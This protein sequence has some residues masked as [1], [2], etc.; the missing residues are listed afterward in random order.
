MKLKEMLTSFFLISTVCGCSTPDGSFSH[1]SDVFIPS[2]EISQEDS[3]STNVEYVKEYLTK[4]YKNPIYTQFEVADPSIIYC[5]EDNY[6]Y[7]LSTGGKI[8]KS[9]NMVYWYP[10]N[11]AFKQIPSWGSYNAGLWAPDIQYINGQYIM[12]YSLSAWNDPNPGIGIATANHP[13]GPWTDHGKLFTSK[14]IGV[15]NSIDPMVYQD[16]DGKI[17]MVWGSMR[18]NFMVELESDGLSLKGGLNYAV[19]NKTRVAGKETHTAW[20]EN[21]Y[22]GAYIVY[23]NGYYYLFLSMGTCCNGLS[24][25]YKVV[26]G[27]S[28]NIL[29]PYLDDQSRDLKTPGSGKIVLDRGDYFVGSGHNSVIK[30][31]KGEY[32]IY[33]HTYSQDYQSY[34]I[35]AMD[36][37]YFDDQGW[38]C[39]SGNKASTGTQENGPTTY[40][41]V[42]K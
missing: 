40:T 31:Q 24:S 19:P 12:Y 36:H 13:E 25:T 23:E 20:D 7:I 15:N 35:L 9:K 5:E 17:Y 1:S 27:R 8:F 11:D 39:V 28:K 38:P 16:F 2:D 6:Y 4:S 32:F 29:G 33:Y 22:E 3:S 30:D 34:R 14:E 42:E 26:V 18:G 21:T 37:M 10:R 41:Y